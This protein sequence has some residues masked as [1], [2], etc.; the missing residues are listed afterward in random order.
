MR[1]NL[2]M[3]TMYI[4]QKMYYADGQV[5][6]TI[7]IRN[8]RT[9]DGLMWIFGHGSFIVSSLYESQMQPSIVVLTNQSGASTIQMPN[10]ANVANV[11]WSLIIILCGYYQI[12]TIIFVQPLICQTHRHLKKK[13]FF[14]KSLCMH[15]NSY[16]VLCTRSLFVT[17]HLLNILHYSICLYF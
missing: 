9:K 13:K 14:L 17:T 10:V 16:A 11:Y 8:D 15:P 2:Q 5:C 1:F 7:L 4:E 6:E 12:M 3:E